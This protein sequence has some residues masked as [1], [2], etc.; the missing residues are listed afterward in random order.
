LAIKLKRSDTND[1]NKEN[2]L[3]SLP[4]RIIAVILACLFAGTALTAKSY[5]LQLGIENFEP[6]Y[7]K[8]DEYHTDVMSM[9]EQL[10]IISACYLSNVDSEWNFQ[11]AKTLLSDLQY[12]MD[13]NGYKYKKTDKGIKPESSMFNYY[14]SFQKEDGSFVY[15]TNVDDPFSELDTM[16]EDETIDWL[17]SKNSNYILRRNGFV[18]SDNV[19]SGDILTYIFPNAT[20]GYYQNEYIDFSDS[21][22]IESYP[23]NFVPVGGWYYDNFGRYFYNFGNDDPIRFYS[24]AKNTTD[25]QIA[26]EGIA[27]EIYDSKED[28]YY[29]S[30]ND[31]YYYDEYYDSDEY[32]DV[33]EETY[34]NYGLYLEDTDKYKAYGGDDNAITVFISPKSDVIKTAAANYTNVIRQYRN[35]QICF[36]LSVF[37]FML[38][39]VYII[40]VC[41]FDTDADSVLK[42]KKLKFF[43][44]CP[45]ELYIIIF[46]GFLSVLD[47]LTD[48]Y[49]SVIIWFSTMLSMKKSGIVIFG[50][51]IAA[52]M[53]PMIFSVMQIAEKFKTH[54]IKKNIFILNLLKKIRSK[55][56]NSAY[57]A[58]YQK[59]S[60]GQKFAKRSIIVLVVIAFFIVMLSEFNTESDVFIISC[61]ISLIVVCVCEFRNLKQYKDLSKISEQIR[62]IGS[63]ED[64]N[65]E[66][67]KNSVVYN[68]SV[69]LTQISD[70]V[71]TSVENQI[72]S[73]RMKIELVAN[74]SHDLKTPLTSIISYIDLLKKMDL[75]DE[76]AAYVQVLD[77]KSQKLKSIV[78][79]VF[80]LAKATSGIDV[81]LTKLDFV[82]LFNQ[83]LA[84]E[85]D[86]IQQSGRTIKTDISQTKAYVMADGDKLYRVF[87][88]LMDN[89]LNY[90]LDGSRIFF[91]IKN[92]NDNIMFISKNISSYPIEF[93]A[94]EIAERFVRG[95]KSRTDGGSGLGLSI[96]KS[97]TEACD[98]E[99]KIELDGDMFKTVVSMPIYNDE[100]DDILALP[101]NSEDRPEELSSL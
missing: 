91:E 33:D 77:K 90:S 28:K 2:K 98:G 1:I 9:Y 8:S 67:S 88:N 40:A 45:V 95:D 30:T 65:I 51:I 36:G 22:D 80:S 78:A 59:K 54:T 58:R 18:T 20:S 11:G 52:V 3:L 89:A 19:S 41:G 74:V 73:E 94:E 75:D 43:G 96:A 66:I 16:S 34:A 101:E 38:L 68:D 27:T 25:G 61:F 81:N 42:W 44:E 63:D 47:I 7:L 84:D 23:S 85:Y 14:V 57:Y 87:Q 6:E 29:Y 64:K 32:Y 50:S 21:Y 4:L 100:P 12:Y 26:R 99:F 83:A 97:F 71:K 93:T 72:K 31:D 46:I 15:M 60:M 79:D 24:Y 92:E 13:Y 10:C 86:K 56:E 39:S 69:M 35:S 37:A 5:S 76:A 55:Y 82:M 48:N 53:F 62:A 49:M 70:K 17:K